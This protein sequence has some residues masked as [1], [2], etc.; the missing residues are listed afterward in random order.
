MMPSGEV[1]ADGKLHRG[2]CGPAVGQSQPGSV[3]VLRD[4]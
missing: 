2:G 1:Y 4:H 3:G